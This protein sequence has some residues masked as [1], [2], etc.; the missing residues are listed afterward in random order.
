MP[1]PRLGQPQHRRSSGLQ[2]AAKIQ[3]LVI[4]RVSRIKAG[5]WLVGAGAEDQAAATE[6]IN[7]QGLKLE[8]AVPWLDPSAPEA[9]ARVNPTATGLQLA[10]GILNSCAEQGVVG[11]TLQL[12]LQALQL[13]ARRKADVWI[14]Q[15]DP[16][17]V[18]PLL[19]RSKS[20]IAAS[21]K[22]PALTPLQHPQ[23]DRAKFCLEGCRIKGP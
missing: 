13:M 11:V 20:G 2:T 5:R 6:P 7:R 18:A 23:G 10:G 15:P 16:A 1:K 22:A 4:Q 21:G 8:L 17:P 14:E 12:L 19:E 3:V 9:Q